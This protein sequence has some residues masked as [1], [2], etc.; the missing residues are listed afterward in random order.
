MRLLAA[1]N[2]HGGEAMNPLLWFLSLFV[3]DCAHRYRERQGGILMLVCPRCHAAE[4]AIDRAGET[5]VTF[6]P[7]HETMK[8]RPTTPAR[9]LPMSRRGQ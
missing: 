7:A 8:A 1:E 3:C 4:P 2:R 6:Q 5:L 9:V